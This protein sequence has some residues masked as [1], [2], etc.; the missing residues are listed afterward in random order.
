M[1]HGQEECVSLHLHQQDVK[2][3]NLNHFQLLRWFWRID[4]RKYDSA[5][6]V[7][8]T[9]FV[10]Y[11]SD[12]LTLTI[13]IQKYL[14]YSISDKLTSTSRRTCKYTIVYMRNSFLP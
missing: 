3:L 7:M 11:V 10:R 1:K 14:Y 13:L 6:E 9:E 4:Q 12:K 8:M 2:T 5:V